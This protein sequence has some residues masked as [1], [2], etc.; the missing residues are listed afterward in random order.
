MSKKDKKVIKIKLLGD[1][2]LPAK[3]EAGAWIGLCSS[4]DITL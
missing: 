1:T 2:R 4:E 3:I